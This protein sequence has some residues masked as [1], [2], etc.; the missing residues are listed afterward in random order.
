[1]NSGA[2]SGTSV[3]PLEALTSVK[4]HCDPA[5][6]QHGMNLPTGAAKILVVVKSLPQ[7]KQRL[8]SWFRA[9]IEKDANL[10]IENTTKRIE[11]PTMG[12]DLLAVLLL[13]TEY[14]LHR[15]ERARA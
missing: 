13:Q 15:R 6:A 10:R 1:M 11:K 2:P 9:C 8:R 7:S 3:S 14:H 5:F 4:C 12:V